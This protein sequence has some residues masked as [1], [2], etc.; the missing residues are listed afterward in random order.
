MKKQI[1]S[2]VVLTI[3]AFAVLIW[4]AFSVSEYF[5]TPDRPGA[6]PLVTRRPKIISEY[7]PPM[8]EPEPNSLNFEGPSELYNT[9]GTAK[10]PEEIVDR[11]VQIKDSPVE[12]S[13]TAFRITKSD[14]TKIITDLKND[15]K[16]FPAKGEED[17]DPYGSYS[18]LG[19][20]LYSKEYNKLFF[21]VN[22]EAGS[23]NA[24]HYIYL[25]VLDT[26]T[27]QYHGADN[28]ENSMD[29]KF[30]PDKKYI[31]FW[32]GVRLYPG[33]STWPELI[34][35]SND[36]KIV[37]NPE[38]NLWEYKKE[39]NIG[40]EVNISKYTEIISWTDDHTVNL[41]EEF[42]V[43]GISTTTY[44]TYNILTDT[45]TKVATST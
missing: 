37:I 1:I 24:V 6:S 34:D 40:D 33:G 38:P 43:G 11:F 26:L 9:D 45:Y 25:Y 12:A 7:V 23:G 32:I 3:L 30:S 5:K 20:F 2:G 4:G 31:Q 8:S 15:L 44:W 27:G 42:E 18:G 35:V 14:G 13:Y 39:H 36:K 29:F 22:N 10:R 41:K 16:P 17:F 28:V 19:D 21:T